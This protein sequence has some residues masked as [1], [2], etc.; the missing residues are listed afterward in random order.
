VKPYS[1]G[2]GSALPE[3]LFSEDWFT[4]RDCVNGLEDESVLRAVLA[5]DPDWCVRAEAFRIVRPNEEILKNVALNDPDW[6]LRLLAAQRLYEAEDDILVNIALNDVNE[7]VRSTA[8]SILCEKMR[9]N[10]EYNKPNSALLDKMQE[11][12]PKQEK[13]YRFLV[14]FDRIIF[15]PPE[16]NKNFCIM[17]T[18]EGCHSSGMTGGDWYDIFR[19]IRA[20]KTNTQYVEMADVPTWGRGFSV[21]YLRIKPMN[22]DKTEVIFLDCSGGSTQLEKALRENRKNDF[23]ALIDRGVVCYRRCRAVLP[24]QELCEAAVQ[25]VL[26][27]HDAIDYVQRDFTRDWEM[28][29]VHAGIR[30]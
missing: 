27:N 23:D 30:Y 26:F 9:Q 2:N 14:D 29:E 6:R 4:R 20:A 28:E 7:Q 5:N 8:V 25:A 22:G 17:P 24:Y 10:S 16:W 1:S 13:R 12:L 3:D 15:S 19:A 18:F 21:Y 11:F